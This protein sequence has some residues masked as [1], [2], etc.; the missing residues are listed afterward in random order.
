MKTHSLRKLLQKR[1]LLYISGVVVLLIILLIFVTIF[2][3]KKS[4][5]SETEAIIELVEKQSH[6]T[7]ADFKEELEGIE[8]YCLNDDMDLLYKIYESKYYKYGFERI[9]ILDLKGQVMNTIPKD[10]TLIGF[11]MSKS[12]G[13]IFAS[14]AGEKFQVGNM[15]FDSRLG[16]TIL[17]NT[18]G[19]DKG[20]VIGYFN[21]ES[22]EEILD[23]IN[24]INGHIAIVDQSGKYIAHSHRQYV[25]ERWISEHFKDL[26]TII[27]NGDR[28]T[29]LEEECFIRYKYIEELDITILYY[30]N[31]DIYISSV[32]FIGLIGIAALLVVVLIMQFVITRTM[33]RLNKAF[34]QLTIVT[35]N[36]AGGIYKY[37]VNNVFYNEMMPLLYSFKH[38]SEKIE[39]REE[40]IMNLTDARE[41]NFYMVIS[42]MAKAIEAKD[43]YTGNHC[44]RVRDFSVAVGKE[45]GMDSDQLRDLMYGSILHDIG[46]IGIDESLLNKP[47]KL[48]REEYAIICRHP[49]IGSNILS[50]VPMFE[51]ANDIIL[52]HHEAQDG[53]GYPEGLVGD[54]IPL[55]ARIVSIADAYDAM[56]SK[57][58][59]RDTYMNNEEAFKEL[60][61]CS[62]TQFDEELVKIFKKVCCK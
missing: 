37:D 15:N 30:Q 7:F 55:M 1:L 20:Y 57:R 16:K 35:D 33:S 46:K 53:S 38:M 23:N 9:E 54:E 24:L 26:D 8:Q 62:G 60:D 29:Y 40:E 34:E 45:I 50:E 18:K 44:E 2:Q 5:D 51:N 19:N 61:R 56:T 14:E 6:H 3:I 28:I 21:S 17:I 11:D 47:G 41:E 52:Y 43:L 25:E 49:R 22:L 59:Y 32:R 39:S 48:T 42:L 58:P 12:E 36:I 10:E 31:A 4:F 27:N 13:F